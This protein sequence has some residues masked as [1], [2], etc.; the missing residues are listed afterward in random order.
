[1]EHGLTNMTSPQ[2]NYKQT[3]IIEP[4]N[5]A[6]IHQDENVK[7][8]DAS[9]VLPGSPVNPQQDF[10]QDHIEGAQFFDVDE[11]AE[12]DTDLP[13]MLPSLEL[14]ARHVQELG[15]NNDD[16]VIIYG[17]S[18]MAM[19]PARAWWMFRA[20]GH[21]NVCVLNGG[22]PAWKA[23]GLPTTNTESI[24]APSFVFKPALKQNLISALQD[25]QQAAK[26]ENTPILDARPA[27][28]FAGQQPEP[29]AG[30]ASGHIP[31]SLNIESSALT[32]PETGKIKPPE[33]LETI[34]PPPAPN[35]KIIASCGSGVTACMIALAYFTIGYKEVSV[36]D[37][38]WA[39]YGQK[40]L[41]LP[42]ET[43]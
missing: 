31:G 13:H 34:L 22:L 40:S 43:E 9:F 26:D 10:A 21:D 3:G 35:Q 23:E 42:I 24:A 4:Q 7:L 29:R 1:M 39:E 6:R 12:P 14:F 15:I 19:G 33:V 5:L 28:R 30:L 2:P 41:N 37:G 20:M 32:D 18:A 27:A 11:I 17:Q 36:Y 25:V 38:S 8:L 16:L